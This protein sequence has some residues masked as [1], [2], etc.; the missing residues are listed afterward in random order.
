MTVNPGIKDKPNFQNRSIILF[1]I[2]TCY[3]SCKKER[4]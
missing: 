1:K 2:S 4:E 3:E